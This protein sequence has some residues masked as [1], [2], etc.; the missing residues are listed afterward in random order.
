MMIILK[1]E[2]NILLSYVTKERLSKLF[3]LPQVWRKWI[4]LFIFKGNFF[5]PSK[6][7]KKKGTGKQFC[8]HRSNIRVGQSIS[9]RTDISHIQNSGILPTFE[10]G[11]TPFERIFIE[12]R[13]FCSKKDRI[14][15]SS[16]WWEYNLFWMHF[17][18]LK[19]NVYV[20]DMEMMQ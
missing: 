17:H 10:S 1:Y 13:N 3:I 2:V 12:E 11:T 15:G 16:F 5:L 8:N 19:W 18:L 4:S 6:T 14:H 20:L 9:S 7:K